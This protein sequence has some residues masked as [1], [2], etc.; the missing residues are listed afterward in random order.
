MDFNIEVHFFCV[1]LWRFLVKLL[2]MGKKPRNIKNALRKVV[3]WLMKPVQE[4]FNFFLWV[5]L[6]GCS[7][8][9]GYL[10][11]CAYMEENDLGAAFR[12]LALGTAVSYVLTV[13]VHACRRK[14]LRIAVKTLIYFALLTL[15]AVYVFIQ[16]NFDMSLGPRVLIL[17]AETTSGE[18][19]EFVNA[20]F[21]SSKS[22]WTYAIVLAIIVLAVLGEKKRHWFSRLA[23]KKVM[24]WVL[25]ILILPLVMWGIGLSYNYV[26]LARCQ[27]SK[28]LNEWVRGFGIDALDHLS[29][30]YYSLCYLGVSDADLKQAVSVAQ[31]VASSPVSVAEPDSLNVVFVLGESYIKSH[32]ALYGY[33]HNTTPW[34][35]A[36]RDRGNLV[37]FTDIVT[38]YNATSTVQKNVFALNDKHGGEMWYEK[39]IF[40]TVFRH[41]GYKVYFWDNQRNYSKTE[42]FTITVNSFIYNDIIAGLSYDE[43]SNNAITIDGNLLHDFKKNSRVE[44]GKLNLYIFHLMGQHVHP[45]GRY[46]KK[47]GF[48]VFTADSVHRTDS[49]LT[50]KKR[51]YIA[52]YDNATRYNDAVMKSIF[53]MWREKNTVVVYL[54]DHGDEAYDWRDHIG[55]G[56]VT[57]PDARLF[58]SD[59]DVPMV[60]WCSDTYIA[61][62]PQLVQQLRTV[63]TCAGMTQDVG[64]MLLR[65]AGIKTPY[66]QPQRDISNPQYQPQPRIVYDKYDYDEVVKE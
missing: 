15:E 21:L 24:R 35:I 47:C 41:A 8:T 29:T 60:V 18:A 19:R 43:T 22:L 6:V 36:E 9:L 50:A 65:L 57:G 48:D 25:T 51:E 63:A 54:S 3:R 45:V 49:Y 44:P 37:V 52:Q 17:L 14:W 53:D 64:F 39:P 12:G 26:K 28:E 46:P 32:S 2:P 23:H 13:I 56:N 4:E 66:Y 38:P 58:H 33:E 59:N 5:W 34:M 1:I 16:L 27:H 10:V 31:A 30:T 42:M 62:H 7:M 40:P 20:Y 61:R 55:R 11:G